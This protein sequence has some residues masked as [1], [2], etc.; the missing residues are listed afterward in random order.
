ML[1]ATIVVARMLG[2]AVYGEFGVIRSTVDMFVVFAGF[3]LGLTAT[4]HVAEFRRN[5]PERAGRII[6]LSWLVAATTGGLMA[7]TLF[8]LAPWLAER[9]I[10]APH[11]TGVL[12]VGALCLFLNALNGAQ[13]GV[14]A[15]FEAFRTVA[16]VNLVVGLISFPI[17][18][19]GAYYGGLI[20]TVWAM[21]ANLAINWLLNHLALRKEA[22]RCQVPLS[23]THCLCELSVLW[24]F[25]LPAVLAGTM[26]GPVR[27]V[28]NA[29]LA[30]QPHGYDELGVFSAALV[31]QQLTLSAGEM[32]N[33]PLLST[34][35]NVGTRSSEKLQVA[36]ILSS[37]ILGVAV[38]IPLLC[39]PEIAQRLFGADFSTRGFTLASALVVFCT[40]IMAFKAGL[41]RVLAANGLLWWGFL[42]NVSWAVVLIGSAVFFVPWGA[43]G[44]AASF[45]LAYAVNTAVLVPLYRSRKLV[46]KGTLLSCDAGLIWFVLLTLVFLNYMDVPLHFRA[47]LFGPAVL[48]PVIAFIRLMK[49]FYS[50]TTTWTAIPV[51]ANT[52]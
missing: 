29:M 18:V 34:L 45:T 22:R 21:A 32:L 1:L 13:T 50:D 37:W 19:G 47:V 25:S 42:S 24:R 30:N 12:Q 44:L 9:T 27:W 39:F 20:G 51:R 48:L 43:T 10:D 49:P 16:W 46:P 17:L 6:A 33:A 26:V 3:G 4:K 41:A 2:K 31:F 28:C 5:D 23:F 38:A 35:S 15:G 14:L 36:N 8:L 11:L 52:L 7:L 40:T